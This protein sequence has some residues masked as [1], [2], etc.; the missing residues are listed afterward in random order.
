MTK[1][2]FDAALSRCSDVLT[3]PT[4]FFVQY[5]AENGLRIVP[6]EP[7]A[8][9]D[10]VFQDEVF[11]PGPEIDDYRNALRPLYADPEDSK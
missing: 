2:E 10:K 3:V 9:Q 8:W 6:S 5:F 11:E 1:T 7:V 4:E